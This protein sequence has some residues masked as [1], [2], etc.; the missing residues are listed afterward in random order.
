VSFFVFSPYRLLLLLLPMTTAVIIECGFKMGMFYVVGNV[1]TCFLYS[2]PS[3]ASPGVTVTSATG[4]HKRSMSHANVQAFHSYGNTINFMPRGLND[5]FPNLIGI[6]ITDVGMKELHQSDLKD[7]PRLK[8]LN[9][10]DNDITTIEQDLFKFNPELEF[11]HL[12]YNK[13]TQIHPT[14]FDHLNKLIELRLQS[15]VCIDTQALNQLATV[16]LISRVKQECLGDFNIVEDDQQASTQSS[17]LK[18]ELNEATSKQKTQEDEIE[19]LRE[20]LNAVLS[21]AKE[22]NAKHESALLAMQKQ[23]EEINALKAQTDKK[24][25]EMARK[26]AAL[27]AENEVLKAKEGCCNELTA[28]VVKET[29]THEANVTAI[30]DLLNGKFVNLG[31][32]VDGQGE[33]IDECASQLVVFEAAFKNFIS[34]LNKALDGDEKKQE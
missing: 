31:R 25:A 15:N 33:R 27:E 18:A 11:I 12:G 34:S 23:G 3:I 13:I 30:I 14:V 26:V 1:Y 6:H 21:M 29:N 7:F 8:H 5:V 24:V 16:S 19:K 22:T 28:L 10:F 17:S 2:D 9:L 4:N 32:K 20:D